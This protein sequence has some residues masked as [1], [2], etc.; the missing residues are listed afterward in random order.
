MEKHVKPLIE[1][2]IEFIYQGKVL[3]AYTIYGTFPGEK[4]ATIELLAAENNIDP[5]EITTRITKKE[6]Q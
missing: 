4:Q 1:E 2:W 5:K 3:L 6:A